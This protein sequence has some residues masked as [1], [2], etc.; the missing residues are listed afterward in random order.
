MFSPEHRC[1]FPA[2]IVVCLFLLFPPSSPAQGK[3]AADGG[4]K[5]V[6]VIVLDALRADH[7][8]CYGYPRNT[9]PAIDRLARQGIVF[10]RA[11][12]QAG[13]TKPSVSSYFTSMY[14][15]IHKVLLSEDMFPANLT[16]MAEIF[17]DNG[18]FTLGLVNNVHIAPDFN[19]NR[20]FDIY[21]KSADDEIIDRLQSLLTKGYMDDMDL[22]EIPEE[23][24]AELIRFLDTAKEKNL[25]CNPGFELGGKGGIARPPG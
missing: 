16:T 1:L 4:I 8:G 9:S 3:P 11:I 15:V 6:L 2:V 20:G 17:Q 25:L 13:W 12:A 14:P 10:D 21:R 24:T 19:F 5:N 7:L 22:K 23:K 18:Y